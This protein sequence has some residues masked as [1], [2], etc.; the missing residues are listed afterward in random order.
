[1]Q[2]GI[3]VGLLGNPLN[4]LTK[5]QPDFCE[6]WFHSGKIPEY[7]PLFQMIRKIGCSVGLHFWGS[8][9]DGT[10][11]NLAYPDKEV[12]SQSRKLLHQTIETAAY[13]QAV[14]VNVH[15]CGKLLSKVDFNKKIFMP[16][17]QEAVLNVCLNNLKESLFEAASYAH[18][19]GVMLTVE[20]VARL[21]LGSPWHSKMSRLQP[22]N[23][24]EF[25]VSE[26]EY[27][28]SNPHL[29]FANDFGHTCGIIISK[30]REL[31][32]QHLFTTSQKLALKTKLLHISYIVPPYNG[33][34]YHGCLYDD[35]IKTTA[36]IPNYTE[37]KQLLNL[38]VKRDD[39]YALVEPE[40]DHIGNF[41]A[42]KQLVADALNQSA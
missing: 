25:L 22:Q 2:L 8:L 23:I 6:I 39:V 37:M 36:A 33:T 10:L 38:F 16:Y 7:E 31:V 41:D 1:M 13:H 4:D 18:S 28:F 11:T 34:D 9:N 17:T 30:D 19:L 35:L 32:K 27:I 5:T 26:I 3:K 20:S 21:A 14:Y 24:G 40:K 42:L 12:L 29:F 15:P